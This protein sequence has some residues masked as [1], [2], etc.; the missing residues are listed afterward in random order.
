MNTIHP[1]AL[2][3]AEAPVSTHSE[4]KRREAGA[5]ER[6]NGSAGNDFPSPA[7]FNFSLFPASARFL[8]SVPRRDC[9]RPLRRREMRGFSSK[10][11]R[12]CVTYFNLNQS[13][14]RKISGEL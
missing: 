10:E 2:S 6:E 12:H 14:G 13:A 8:P 1:G 5:L 4:R 3:S 9:R 11:E 7:R